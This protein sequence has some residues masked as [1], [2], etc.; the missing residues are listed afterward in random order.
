M[1]MPENLF[2]SKREKN[3][4]GQ[5]LFR[6]AKI[7]TRRKNDLFSSCGYKTKSTPSSKTY[8]AIGLIVM[9]FLIL[10]SAA[11]TAIKSLNNNHLDNVSCIK[12]AI[13]EVHVVFIVDLTDGLPAACLT[14][15]QDEFRYRLEK[16]QVYQQ[17]SLY[18][19][20]E[21]NPYS[22]SRGVCLFSQCL[23]RDG[24]DADPFTE[25]KQ[26]IRNKF[27][28]EFLNPLQKTIEE[29]DP[30]HRAKQSPILETLKDLSMKPEFAEAEKREVYYFGNL[31]QNSNSV[32][33]Y[34]QGWE[35]FEDLKKQSL[36]VLD[37]ENFLSGANV[38]LFLVPDPMRTSKHM[39]W[40]LGYFKYADAAG[41]I[42]KGL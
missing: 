4:T 12:G 37:V 19:I 28:E 30:D 24:S 23:P 33:Q 21:E 27:E 7:S 13:P 32:N 15:F 26:R 42:V 41:Y 18:V 40:W 6:K 5:W 22:V 31:L 9:S 14:A 25:H 39:E 17:I 8:L 3:N 16:L 36:R 10:A 29:I 11:W 35:G 20:R 34:G 1:F 38:T 2:R